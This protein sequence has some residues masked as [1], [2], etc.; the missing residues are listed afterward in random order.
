MEIRMKRIW[1][2]NQHVN[3]WDAS[4]RTIK[5]AHHLSQK[6]YD[7]TIFTSSFIHNTDINLIKDN[8]PYIEKLYGDLH[9]VHL[10]TSNYKNNGFKRF[11]GFIQFPLRLLIHY[12]RFEKPDIIL[13]K[14][15]VPWGNIIIILM[16]TAMLNI[17]LT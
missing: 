10:R 2:V 12:K 9:F 15:T 7:V 5:F 14:A 8:S 11:L 3:P 16:I 1:L 13:H 17:G 4:F 6:G